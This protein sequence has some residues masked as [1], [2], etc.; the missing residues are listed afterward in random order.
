MNNVGEVFILT[1]ISAKSRSSY[2]VSNSRAEAMQCPNCKLEN[3]FSALK[4]SCGYS[5]E[6]KTDQ[7]P[8]LSVKELM[9]IES[10]LNR[11]F[12]AAVTAVIISIVI[13]L[14]LA[15]VLREPREN[16]A[17]VAVAIL[18]VAILALGGYS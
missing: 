16:A 12:Y 15:P 11:S 6:A 18:V 17:L 14:Y 1:G 9:G 7:K 13:N 5:F 2:A 8:G 10:R 4:C 3:S